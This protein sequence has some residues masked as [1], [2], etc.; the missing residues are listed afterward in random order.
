[1]MLVS[2]EK[3]GIIRVKGALSTQV[4]SLVKGVRQTID[5]LPSCYH[6]PVLS[7]DT[8]DRT[9][10]PTTR[11]M[12]CFSMEKHTMLSSSCDFDRHIVMLSSSCDSSCEFDCST[13]TC[14]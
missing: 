7:T 5:M 6:H 13:S 11:R 12:P 1:M 4:T 8:S 3:H 9:H 2:I 14:I 10:A